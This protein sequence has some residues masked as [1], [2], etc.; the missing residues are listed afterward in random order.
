MWNRQEP[1]ILISSE[2]CCCCLVSLE[3]CQ[4]SDT[5][6]ESVKKGK[7]GKVKSAGK[8]QGK[9]FKCPDCDYQNVKQSKMI[10]HLRMHSGHKP[11]KCPSCQYESN[12]KSKVC[13]EI[14]YNQ[15]NR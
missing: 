5:N 14:Y 10:R 11:F 8:G 13:I 1:F 7:H 9:S 15:L 4:S 12:D 3:D 2:N 6:R